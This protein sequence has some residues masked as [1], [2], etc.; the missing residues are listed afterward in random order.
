[1]L[2][3]LIWFRICS[4]QA[5][6]SVND[7]KTHNC[8]SNRLFVKDHSPMELLRILN[9][10]TVVCLEVLTAVTIKMAVLWVV[11]T[12]RPDDGGSTDL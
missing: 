11:A 10:S 12:Y 4:C 2:S 3:G 6:D 8:L 7:G 1:M 5:F 9:Y